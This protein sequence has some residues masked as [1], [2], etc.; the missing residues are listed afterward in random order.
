MNTIEGSDTLSAADLADAYYRDGRAMT[1]N[2][3]ISGAGV[4]SGVSGTPHTPQVQEILDNIFED[5]RS[6]TSK[7]YVGLN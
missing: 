6:F 4:V 2:K 7:K 1:F 3:Y 5:P